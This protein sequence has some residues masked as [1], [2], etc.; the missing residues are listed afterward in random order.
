MRRAVCSHEE[1][2]Y[3]L[4][5]VR[6]P[7]SRAEDIRRRKAEVEAITAWALTR[8]TASGG[9]LADIPYS[10]TYPGIEDSNRVAS[11]DDELFESDA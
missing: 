5:Q 10:P 7:K 11:D 3:P 1:L 6:Y 2:L 4:R 9:L 8:S